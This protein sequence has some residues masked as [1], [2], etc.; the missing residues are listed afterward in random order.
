MGPS[1]ADTTAIAIRAL[2]FQ[3]PNGLVALDGLTLS[4]G[5]GELLGVVG[6][7]GCGKSTMLRLIAG[8]DQPAGGT[9]ALQRIGDPVNGASDELSRPLLTMMFQEDSVVPWMKVHANVQ[10]WFK[11]NRRNRSPDLRARADELLEMVGL[12]RYRDLYPSQ[13]SGGMRRRVALVTAVVAEPSILLLDE[14]FS[15][16]DE[17]TRL[18]LHQDLLRLVRRRRMSCCL[19]THD[20]GEAVSLCDRVAVLSGRPGHVAE[21]VDVPL[22]SE[23]NV[24]KLRESEQFL[25][26]YGKVWQA[27]RAQLPTGPRP[28][29]NVDAQMETG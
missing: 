27:L 18:G 11:F 20:I 25:S 12:S 15:A 16:L 8:L 26:L 28:A 24:L 4:V 5:E 7:S 23:R 19:V 3:Y 22:G 1:V 21:L 10:L 17:P 9:I 29:V 13:L 14:P 6:P 2:T